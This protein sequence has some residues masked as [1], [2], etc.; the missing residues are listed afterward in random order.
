MAVEN[1]RTAMLNR[2]GE[3]LD[4]SRIEKMVK[5]YRHALLKG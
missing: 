5:D 1:Y 2:Y 4:E 3:K